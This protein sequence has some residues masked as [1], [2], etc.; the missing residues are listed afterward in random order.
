MKHMALRPVAVIG[1]GMSVFGK[2]PEK[3]LV[4]LGTE[5][6]RAA[7]KDAGISP[8]SMVSNLGYILTQPND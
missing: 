4:E 1:V 3:T 2:Q 8:E 7:I 6:C 5:A